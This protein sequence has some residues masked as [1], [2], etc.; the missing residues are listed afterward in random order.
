MRALLIGVV[1]AALVGAAGALAAG[2]LLL[3]E[4]TLVAIEDDPGRVADAVGVTELGDS[5]AELWGSGEVED[6]IQSAV[7]EAIDDVRSE[8]PDLALEAVEGDPAR[9]SA[10][11][12]NELE[13]T[14]LEVIA[15]NSAAVQDAAN[16]GGPTTADLCSAFQLAS[17]PELSDIGYYGC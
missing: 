10:A 17:D 16:D 15:S 13:D 2:Y 14:I 3:P 5:L 8:V 4:R 6:A 7:S 12:A 1:L 11:L 9:V